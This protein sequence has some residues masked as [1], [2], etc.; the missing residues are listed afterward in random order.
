MT[1]RF[2]IPARATQAERRTGLVNGVAA[3]GLWGLLPLYFRLFPT[4]S[5]VE[6]VAHRIIWSVLFLA[7]LL[8]A[9]RQL[10]ALLTTLGQR[11]IVAALALSALLIAVNW[12]V[13][14]W[15]VSAHHVLAGSLGYF[16]NPL[17][18]V[19][20]GTLFLRETLSRGQKAA[21]ALAAV[22][23]AVLAAGEI[24]TLWI[25]LTLALSFAFYGL[26]RKLTPVPPAVGLA[27]ET[28][29]LFPPAL[30][31]LV[32]F[33][34]DGTLAFGR[35]GPETLL[36]IGL[37][38]ITSV[39]LLLFAG[40][41][42]RLPMVTLGLIQYLAPS[43]QFLISVFVLDEPLSAVRLASFAL[44]WVALALFVRESLRAG[45]RP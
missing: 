18:N 14:I 24:Q 35:P 44:I 32:W 39:P 22:G 26:V 9:I 5:S 2:P 29:I 25:S 1:G 12:L 15:A 36:L 28:L 19:L 3:Y 34:L 23:V 7:I 31:A 8:G 33:G 4:V 13:F 20:I 27:V 38:V 16:L 21:V 17:V 37:G 6:V 42:R 10:P 11:R 41:A 30:A 40:A 43:L 45:P